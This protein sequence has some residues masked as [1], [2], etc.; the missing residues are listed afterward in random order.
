[1]TEHTD[2]AGPTLGAPV[3][4]YLQRLHERYATVTEGEVASYIPELSGADPNWFGIVVA[5]A[6][7]TVYEVGDT[8]QTFTIQSI[9]K[10]F[11][12]ALALDSLGP[13][14]V[15]R[16]VGVEPTGEAFNSIALDPT[17]GRPLNPMVNAGAISIAGVVDEH[18]GD[19]SFSRLAETYGKFAGRA[20][21][22]EQ[23]VYESERDTGHR[24]R[25]T[26]H[27]LKAS[28]AIDV[29][30]E[31]AVD[32]YFRQCSIAVDAHD[33]AVMAATLANGGLNP[34]S[35]DR[36]VERDTV[37]R[38]LTVMS[39]CGMY[40]SA[41]DWLYTV[42]LPAKSGVGGGIVA[43][44]PH[45]MSLCVWSPA[46]DEKGNSLLGGYALH[47]FTRMTGLSVF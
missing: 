33:L 41:G 3:A 28:G 31:S 25:A 1:M 8:H 24:N 18:F 2:D 7:G 26:A 14:E 45:V 30:P 6:D 37:R 17:T 27:L 36:V 38:V 16:H 44:V 35:G 4:A 46:L 34:L 20:L 29:E 12:F 43:V 13:D 21:G 9:S 40:D 32:L 23:E 39:T 15:H 47:R 19:A 22:F 5:T 42:G 11:S 10:A